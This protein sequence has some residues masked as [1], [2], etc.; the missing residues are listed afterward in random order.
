M[1][2]PMILQMKSKQIFI[3]FG[4]SQYIFDKIEVEKYSAFGCTVQLAFSVR[5]ILF[6]AVSVA[7][8]RLL[9]EKMQLVHSRAK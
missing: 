7:I 5:G 1:G 3:I 6:T 2:N 8:E 9:S 4:T